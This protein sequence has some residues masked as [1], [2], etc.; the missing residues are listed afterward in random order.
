MRFLELIK[1]FLRRFRRPVADIGS[2][3]L[4]ENGAGVVG[5]N[6]G[7]GNGERHSFNVGT[8][9]VSTTGATS[10]SGRSNVGKCPY[11][12]SKDF[13]KSGKRVKKYETQQRYFCNDCKRFFVPQLVKGKSFP[14]KVILDG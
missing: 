2:R 13:I 10:A 4:A 6:N 8:G 3:P 9:S 11:C 12:S 5:S 7:T 1:N 14:L